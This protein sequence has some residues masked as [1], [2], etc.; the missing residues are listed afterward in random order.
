MRIDV[1]VGEE[2]SQV[3]VRVPEWRV[4]GRFG[5]FGAVGVDLFY[6]LEVGDGVAG[7]GEADYGALFLCECVSE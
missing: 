1:L 4:E 3:G 5:I 7:W 2:V 6:G